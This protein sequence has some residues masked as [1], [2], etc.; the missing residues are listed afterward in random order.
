MVDI[1]KL[2]CLMPVLLLGCVNRAGSG[3]AATVHGD[4]TA[5]GGKAGDVTSTNEADVKANANVPISNTGPA[6]VEATDP[7]PRADEDGGK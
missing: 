2:L 4:G 6:T 1:R 3:G 7:D 5:T